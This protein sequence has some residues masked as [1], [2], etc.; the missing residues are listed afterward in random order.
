MTVAVF[1]GAF[2]PPHLGHVALVRSALEHFHFERVLVVPAGD[3]PHKEVATP[4]GIRAGLAEL[5]FAGISEAEISPL[6]LAPGG[7]RYTVDTLQRLRGSYDDLTLLVGADQFAGFL[8]WREPERVLE[9][10][11]L[12]VASRPGYDEEELRPVLAALDRPERVSFF[13]IPA[14]PVSSQEI[15]ARVRDGLPIVELVPRPVAA[16]IERLGLYRE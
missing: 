2:D 13:R 9:L 3:P 5:A 14:H 16:E 4:A 6:E 7:P 10:A 1:G 15:R 8:S 11:A 12:A